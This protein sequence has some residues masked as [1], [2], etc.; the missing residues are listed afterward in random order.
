MSGPLPTREVAKP[1]GREQLPAPFNTARPEKIGEIWFEPPPELD[2]LLVKYLFTSEKLSVQVH[3]SNAQTEAKGL[4]RQGKEECWLV[5]DAEP[6]AALAIGFRE[7]LDSDAMR[8][9]ALDGSIEN[10][11]AW[12]PVKRG[13]FFYIPANTVHAIGAGISLIEVQQNSDITYRLYDYGRPRELH[14]EHGVA[15]ARGE[16]YPLSLHRTLPERGAAKL[17]DG[18]WFRLD[19]TEGVPDAETAARYGAGP[20]LV[21]PLDGAV[22]IGDSEIEPGSCGLAENVSEA[23]FAAAGLC[24]LAQSV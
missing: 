7:E 10:L 4:G 9:A 8:A 22:A 3:P 23:R 14:L 17:V 5:L 21:I 20:L 18:P 12:H 15:V 19:R 16:P 11:L 1:W 13:D 6:G 24:L 2:R